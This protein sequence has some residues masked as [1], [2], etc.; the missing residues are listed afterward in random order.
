MCACLSLFHALALFSVGALMGEGRLQC[1]LVA[2]MTLLLL[3]SALRT[4]MASRKPPHALAHGGMATAAGGVTGAAAAEGKPRTVPDAGSLNSSCA[5]VTGAAGTSPADASGCALAS[6][7][8]KSAGVAFGGMDA[9]QPHSY[10]KMKAVLAAAVMLAVNVLLQRL[11]L[12]DRYGKDPHDKAEPSWELLLESSPH[13]AAQ[14]VKELGF[15][16]GPLVGL[17]F[18]W[19]WADGWL[20]KQQ[21]QQQQQGPLQRQHLS[22]VEAGRR[23]IGNNRSLSGE[24]SYSADISSWEHVQQLLCLFGMWTVGVQ[25][26]VIAGFWAAQ[27][28]GTSSYT[29]AE[30][31]VWVLQQLP[32]WGG[33]TLAA[34]GAAAGVRFGLLE[35]PLR[36]L[37]PRMVYVS[38][39][40]M[41]AGA[42][43]VGIGKQLQQACSKGHKK[44]EMEQHQ[45]DKELGAQRGQQLAVKEA[46]LE[47]ECLEGKPKLQVS[48]SV[49]CAD[50]KDGALED[51]KGIGGAAWAGGNASLEQKQLWGRARL[52]LWILAALSGPVVT[53]LGYKGPMLLLLSNVQGI[54]LLVLVRLKQRTGQDEGGEQKQL[55]GGHVLG[56]CQVTAA[57]GVWS[58][59]ALQLF[60]CSGHFCEFSGLQYTS[61]FIGFDEM[62]WYTSGSLLLLNTFGLSMLCWLSLPLVVVVGEGGVLQ[63]AAAPGGEEKHLEGLG[64]ITRDKG[65][66]NQRG[67]KGGI[68]YSAGRNGA[69]GEHNDIGVDSNQVSRGA[70]TAYGL[71]YGSSKRN[72]GYAEPLLGALLLSSSMQMATLCVCLLSAAVQQQH[73]LLWAIFAPKLVFEVMLMS[74]A[75]ICYIFV[76]VSWY[77]C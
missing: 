53:V 29:A 52:W 73:I 55:H 22:V 5:A 34:V 7:G 36:L 50:G 40:G 68:P 41:L 26:V 62:E 30:G 43:V 4:A 65:N 9:V 21:A 59:F 61:S 14:Q 38:G 10:H 64:V 16:L 72:V 35:L 60:F 33:D 23:D 77:F 66:G 27:L 71:L 74:L 45:A 54:A 28:T 58:M 70:K 49:N 1:L 46:L 39:M 15:T 31:I 67:V 56:S 8:W 75:D 2:V 18:L 25:L 6:N 47:G 57:P 13:A 76:A 63:A 3:R 32:A 37:L 11:G 48:P 12:I 44:E 19:W 51:S 24:A 17:G 42:V 20:R 69:L